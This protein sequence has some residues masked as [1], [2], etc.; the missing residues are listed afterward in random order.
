MS[1]ISAFGTATPPFRFDQSS[2]AD[3]MVRTMRLD[4]SEERK[5]RT[6]FRMSGIGSRYSCIGEYGKSSGFE[7]YPNGSGD[8]FPGT[9][10]RMRLYRTHALPL[11][12]AAINNLLESNSSVAVKNVTHLIVV[13]C[14][15]MYAPGLDIDIIKAFGLSTSVHRTC[16]NFMGC[17]AAMNALKTADAICRS[18]ANAKVL[19][20]CTELCSLHFQ[21]KV[22]EDN[23]LANALFGDGSAAMVVERDAAS[24]KRFSIVDFH[25][26]I[27]PEG[28]HDMAWKIADHGF[29]MRLSAYVPALL[30][31]GIGQFFDTL[32]RRNELNKSD[33]RYFAIHPGGKK[34]L[35]AIE[36]ELRLERD[37]NKFS[38]EVLHECGNMSSPTV[39]FVLSRIFDDLTHTDD[40]SL[41]YSAAFGPGLTLESMLLKAEIS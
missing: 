15:G 21:H 22:T 20:V 30:K 35:E 40:G 1:H 2:L 13:S 10:E 4:R 33:V 28:E 27:A 9:D 5:L 37:N 14:T 23:L 11:S 41:V 26:D 7:F 12:V 24:S 6:I 29:E 3:F 39:V 32:L 18:D 17:Y 8:P 31:A 25:N 38:Y 19:I 34:I 16:I 36:D